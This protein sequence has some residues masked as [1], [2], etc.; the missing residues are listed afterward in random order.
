MPGR[1]PTS[2]TSTACT[3][4]PSVSQVEPH[5]GMHQCQPTITKNPTRS[6]TYSKT[7]LLKTSTKPTCKNGTTP[8]PA[9]LARSSPKPLLA[10]TYNKSVKHPPA[11][12]SAASNGNTKS[13]DPTGMADPLH[14]RQ[15]GAIPLPSQDPTPPP[16]PTW[17]HQ[18]E[19]STDT[20]QHLAPYVHLGRSHPPRLLR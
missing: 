12:V 6:P 14:A 11:L 20:T 2:P 18:M 5:H 17:I 10:R 13:G 19:L 9:L 3:G 15:P 1:P 4:T 7:N 8:I 16:R